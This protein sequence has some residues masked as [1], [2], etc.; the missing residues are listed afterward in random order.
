MT[1]PLILSVV[2]L[3]GVLT[4]VGVIAWLGVLAVRDFMR[5]RR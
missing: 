1:D 3:A 2:F 4:T 5:G